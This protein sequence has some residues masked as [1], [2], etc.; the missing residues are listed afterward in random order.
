MSQPQNEIKVQ[1]LWHFEITKND[2]NPLLIEFDAYEN[3]RKVATPAFLMAMILKQH[4]KAIR[5][6][7]G[8]KPIKLGF[9]IL[10]SF[11]DKQQ[12]NRIKTELEESCKLLNIEC[13][14]VLFDN[15]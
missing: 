2:E 15:N 5:I 6:E 3:V 14:F 1:R 7:T 13:R 11:F 9:F 8:I 10:E 12:K 4:K